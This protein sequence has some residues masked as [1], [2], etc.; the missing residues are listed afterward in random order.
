MANKLKRARQKTYSQVGM[1]KIVKK[2]CELYDTGL[3]TLESCCEN[4]EVPIRTWTNW[5]S[6]YRKSPYNDKIKVH[7]LAEVATLWES[8]QAIVQD[9]AKGELKEVGES[10]MLKL[11]KGWEYKE[12][13]THVK[14]KKG[15]DGQEILIPVRHT[16]ATKQILPNAGMIQFALKIVNPEKYGGRSANVSVEVDSSNNLRLRSL[17]EIQAEIDE[18]NSDLNENKQ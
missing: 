2:V 16:I 1:V 7:C 9:L 10:M 13:K 14:I 18:L 15:A 3:Y 4:A 11:I 12:I 8:S 6:T 17:A 5:W